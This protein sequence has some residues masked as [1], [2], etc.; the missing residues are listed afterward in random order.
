MSATLQNI[1]DD[2]RL[3]TGTDIN[4]LPDSTLDSEIDI[5]Y[6][7]EMPM[8]AFPLRLEQYREFDTIP[9][10]DVYPVSQD[11]LVVENPMFSAGWPMVL[12]TQPEQ[13]YNYYPPLKSLLNLGYGN[14]GTSYN[15]SAIYF[16]IVPGTAMVNSGL[17]SLNDD[18]L[19]GLS[20]IQG[21]T[22]TINYLTGAI[23]V[24]FFN[25]V[26]SNTALTG[27]WQS[28]TAAQPR[29]VLF[30]NQELVLRPIPDKAYTIKYQATIRPIALLNAT[31]EPLLQEWRDIIALGTSLRIF[32]KRGDFDQLARYTPVYERYRNLY[33]NRDTEQLAVERI[34]SRYYR[35]QRYFWNATPYPL[36]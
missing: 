29:A 11:T 26:N 6:R 36:R 22:G 14:G 5:F 32:L 12:F 24:N 31:D 7:M 21:G 30:F 19:G 13:F 17:E 10:Q 2:V 4:Q 25:A 33:G 27:E 35:K 8:D 16:P 15:F 3:Y 9:N 20:S 34:P 23:S 1:R 18:G 28:Y